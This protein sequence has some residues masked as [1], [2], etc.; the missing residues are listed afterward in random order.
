[1]PPIHSFAALLLL[2]GLLAGCG[3]DRAE[4]ARLA[5][6]GAEVI[7]RWQPVHR[8]G[9]YVPG[10]KAVYPSSV[11]MNV[12]PARV[13]GV[14]SVALASPPQKEFG[15]AIHPTILGAAGLLIEGVVDTLLSSRRLRGRDAP[16]GHSLAAVCER[17]LGLALDKSEQT[18]NWAC[19][20]LS[21]QQIAYAALDAEVLLRLQPALD[22]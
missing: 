18:S 4:L 7:Q 20:P 12:I 19:R 6:Y 16:G 17:E 2:A 9:F 13:A 5:P 8:V 15:G 1:M 22:G 14:S 3:S 21:P 10:G 11:V